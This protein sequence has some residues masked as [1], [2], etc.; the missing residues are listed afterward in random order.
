MVVSPP[1]SISGA[2]SRAVPQLLAR[3]AGSIPP[4]RVPNYQI[5]PGS[6]EQTSIG[7]NQVVRAIGEFEQGGQKI[8]ELLTWIYTG[9][10]RTFFF[11]KVVSDDLAV[12]QVSLRE[13]GLDMP[14]LMLTSRGQEEDIIL[15][16][17]L[18]ADDYITKP[19]RI[20]ELVA[21]HG[22]RVVFSG[23]LKL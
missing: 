1:A 6:V 19:F 2:L 17:N 23:S 14:I 11:A 16:L 18:G 20:G 8:A 15:G 7:G 3:R 12:L 10:T 4:H 5:R 9:H 21:R 22:E 13:R